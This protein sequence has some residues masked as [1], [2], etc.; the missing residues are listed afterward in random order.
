MCYTVY[1]T[2]SRPRTIPTHSLS[3]PTRFTR[4]TNPLY[5]SLKNSPSSVGRNKGNLGVWRINESFGQVV[6]MSDNAQGEILQKKG[7]S[8][9]QGDW[10]YNTQTLLHPYRNPSPSTLSWVVE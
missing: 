1:F 8:T 7:G 10:S 6:L 2:W 5:V 4:H 9:N 3:S